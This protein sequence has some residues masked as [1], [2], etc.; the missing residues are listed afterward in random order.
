[1]IFAF[2]IQRNFLIIWNHPYFS[3]IFI[4][5]VRKII[6]FSMVNKFLYETS[7][8][9]LGLKKYNTPIVRDMLY[10]LLN[11]KSL[12][13]IDISAFNTKSTIDMKM[14]FF[15]RSSLIDLNLTNFNTINAQDMCDVF[16]MCIYINI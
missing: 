13:F 14:M 8:K 10:M 1:M 6:T 12:E 2:L 11:C 4:Y 16:N 3:M 7:L 15:K 5:I 9:F